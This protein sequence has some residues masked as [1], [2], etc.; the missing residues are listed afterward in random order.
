MLS[1]K[2]SLLAIVSAFGF[3][4]GLTIA[5]PALSQSSQ[6]LNLYSARHYQTDEALYAE[7]T[8]Q[9]GIKI[10]RIEADDNA[11]LER[12]RSEGKN[13]PAD[14]ILLVDAARLWR[15]EI[16]GFFQPIQSKVLDTR[17]PKNFRSNDIGQGSQWF[18]FSS[19]ARVIVYNKASM[20]PN[21][22]DTYE[23]LADP[24]NKGKVCTRSGSHPYML[25]LI[26]AM[27]EREG[28]AKTEAWAK[29]MVANMARAPKGGDTDQ[30]RAVASGEC[31]V[32]LTNSYYLAR[33]MRSTKPADMQVVAKVSLIWP[34]QASSGAHM[35]I[36][37]G[38]VASYAPNKAAAI[39]FLEYLA[40][41][42]AQQYFANG[43]NEWPRIFQ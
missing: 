39:K 1:T 42:S 23:K 27:Y 6:V 41:D 5:T 12:L 14:V 2:K 7:F 38:A 9:T 43:N 3:T 22:I 21:N 17:I 10:N 18:G 37:G 24:I 25:S 30:I 4:A 31:G 35:N 36:A 33:L 11:L 13:S 15:A 20:S 32:A 26:G 40:S 28:E 19:R 34:N 8:K 29:G 16:E